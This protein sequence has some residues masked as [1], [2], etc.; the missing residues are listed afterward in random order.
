MSGGGKAE[1]RVCVCDGYTVRFRAA[2]VPVRR[3][4]PALRVH[5]HRQ[6]R[7]IYHLQCGSTGNAAVAWVRLG[8]DTETEKMYGQLLGYTASG[9]TRA[10]ASLLGLGVRTRKT[11][12]RRRHTA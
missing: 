1:A 10:E 5:R 8:L 6:P 2:G 7:P 3:V 11:L 4:L 9:V 12:T